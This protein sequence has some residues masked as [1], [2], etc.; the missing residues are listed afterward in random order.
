MEPPDHV[1]YS[2]ELRPYSLAL[3]CVTF[4]VLAT[5]RVL[6]REGR[7]QRW[8]AALAI[9]GCLYSPY[10]AALVILTFVSWWLLDTAATGRPEEAGR[11]K[12]AL[13]G[14]PAV[15]LGLGLAYLLHVDHPHGRAV[16]ASVV[17]LLTFAQVNGSAGAKKRNCEPAPLA[18]DRYGR[19]TRPIVCSPSSR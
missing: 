2:Q 19:N 9:L 3:L 1:H 17:L 8:L 16:T 10:F 15:L 11:A 12:R 6:F 4:A 5:D 7:R 14:S 13:A 18:V